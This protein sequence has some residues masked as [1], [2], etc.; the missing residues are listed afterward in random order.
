MTTTRINEL[1]IA[2]NTTPAHLV[3][4][5]DATDLVLAD[6]IR[7]DAGV[8]VITDSVIDEILEDLD[9]A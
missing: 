9:N 5:F 7:T 6:A 3:M 8:D 1:A 4:T 2:R